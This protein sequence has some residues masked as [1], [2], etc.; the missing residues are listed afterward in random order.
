MKI[1]PNDTNSITLTFSGL[2]KFEGLLAGTEAG[3]EGAL[4][5]VETGLIVVG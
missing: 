4:V 5:A 1:S 3:F 2:V